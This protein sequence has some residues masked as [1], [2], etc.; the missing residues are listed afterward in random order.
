MADPTSDIPVGEL[1]S[2]AYNGRISTK[3]RIRS[4]Y[5]QPIPKSHN[6]QA[7]PLW[8]IKFPTVYHSLCTLA[9]LDSRKTVFI[10]G[11]GTVLG[12]LGATLAIELGATVFA[13]VRSEEESLVLQNIGLPVGH[14]LNANDVYQASFLRHLMGGGCGPDVIFN[15]FG[16]ADV[17]AQLWP[18]IAPGGKF[19]DVVLT[20]ASASVNL[21]V[22]PF[23][24]GAT[25]DIV[26]LQDTLRKDIHQYRVIREEAIAFLR[27]RSLTPVPSISTFT[28]DRIQQVVETIDA[29]SGPESVVLLFQEADAVPILPEDKNFLRLSRDATYVLAGG[30]GGLGRSLARLMVDS[31][32]RHLVFLSRSGP[33]SAAAESIIEE[34]V[35]RDVKVA[36]HGCDIA[37]AE[38]LAQAFR[39]I[40]DDSSLPPVKGIIQCAAV[41]RDSIF[42]NMTYDQWT[43]ALRPKIQGT[44]NLHQA[45]LSNP[46]AAEGLDFFVMLASIS[47][48]VGNRGQANYAAGNSY[49]DALA[50]YRRSLGLAATSVDLGLMQDIGLI[51]EQGGQSNLKDD[52]VVPL[53]AKDFE[54]IF[55][56]VL[57]SDR[58]DVPAQ[59]ITGLPTGGILQNLGV[60][61]LPFYFHDARFTQMQFLGLDESL[62]GQ[63][64]LHGSSASPEERLAA[65]D[66]EQASSVVLEIL[67]GHIAKT[68]R[69]SANDID[70]TKP[71]HVYGVDSLM[72]V[73]LRAWFLTK[74]KA[75]ISLFEILSG[76]SIQLLADKIAKA[77]KLVK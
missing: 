50:Y 24:Q 46:C 30:L 48:F 56:L 35:P 4:E 68:L 25:F 28:A 34:F 31:G 73:D 18:C 51:A 19:V 45:S 22:E 37:D 64:D 26:N 9:K 57:D 58:R 44:W 14:L 43:E 27:S 53:S 5:V 40:S 72:A 76:G 32:A 6:L 59:I 1:V 55:K 62:Q 39:A 41:L 15:T 17:I 74:L 7:L 61:S 2:L 65:A 60:D 20:D 71:L 77:S 8:S 67:Q 13:S 49:Q 29:G 10:Q 23:R 47:G 54:L 70:V 16:G 69:C 38:S 36:I 12:Q 21:A 42:D 66:A 63:K 11:G 3:V 75:E 33:G 52:T